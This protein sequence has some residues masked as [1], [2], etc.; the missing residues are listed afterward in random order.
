M[1]QVSAWKTFAYAIFHFTGEEQLCGELS[2]G[3]R[4]VVPLEKS[5]VASTAAGTSAYSRKNS[6]QTRM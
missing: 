3:G 4:I 1:V 2:A 5:Q 6:A